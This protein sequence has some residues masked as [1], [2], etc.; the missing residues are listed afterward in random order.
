[1]ITLKKTKNRKRQIIPLSHALKL[2]LKEYLMIRGGTAE[3]YLICT[4]N[5]TQIAVR[6]LQQSV[7]RYNHKRGVQ[8]TGLHAFRHSFARDWIVSG[9]DPFRLQRILGHADI[10]TTKQYVQLY[11]N[12]L[13]KDFEKFNALDRISPRSENRIKMR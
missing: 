11:G 10:S 9:G 2:T 12:D 3:D 13:S 1:M 7:E 8:R 4:E 5:G 6:S